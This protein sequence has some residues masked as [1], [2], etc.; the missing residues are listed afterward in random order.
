MISTICTTCGR[1]YQ[2]PD[3]MAGKKVRCKQCGTVFPIP[4]GDVD[5]APDDALAE[6]EKTLANLDTATGETH[7]GSEEHGAT[8]IETFDDDASP[9]ESG[10]E[11]A[12]NDS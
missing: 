3:A 9:P 8:H 11:A 7:V 5:A 10:D 1:R 4:G 12:E 6:F 2:A